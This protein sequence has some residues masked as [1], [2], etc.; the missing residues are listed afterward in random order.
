MS[1]T[2]NN[3]VVSQVYLRSFACEEQNGSVYMS[4]LGDDG[5]CP[6]SRPV[7]IKRACSFPDFYSIILD[8]DVDRNTL[9]SQY[10][11]LFE[12]NWPKVIDRLK[13]FPFFVYRCNNLARELV[14][15]QLQ[16]ETLIKYLHHQY[17]KSPRMKAK[18]VLMNEKL[19]ESHWIKLDEA[20][21]IGNRNRQWTERVFNHMTFTSFLK[22]S[23]ECD[24]GIIETLFKK[25]NWIIWQNSTPTPFITTDVPVLWFDELSRGSVKTLFAVLSPNFAIEIQVNSEM[26]RRLYCLNANEQQVDK[27]NSMMKNYAFSKL[28]SNERSVIERL[29][30]G[31]NQGTEL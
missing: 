31:M 7:G 27:F 28:V 20:I 30:A 29:I 8:G 24:T 1:E 22:Q 12:D 3:H 16:E 9:E 13:S 26:R 5:W 15:D 21:A 6:P 25:K 23:I 17:K 11:Q 2:K 10:K 18:V 14:F 4:S 19:D